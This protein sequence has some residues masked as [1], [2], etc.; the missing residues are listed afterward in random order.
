MSRG[1]LRFLE[2]SLA[3]FSLDNLSLLPLTKD[4]QRRGPGLGRYLGPGLDFI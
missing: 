1:F 3:N 4:S 2:I